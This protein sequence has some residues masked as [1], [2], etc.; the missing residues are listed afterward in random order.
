MSLR[1][2]IPKSDWAVGGS[3]SYSKQS[4]NYRLTEVG[5][6]TGRAGLR[7]TVFV[8]NKDVFG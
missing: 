2:D 6:Q 8:E 7:P 4:L 1:Y 3:A 5:L